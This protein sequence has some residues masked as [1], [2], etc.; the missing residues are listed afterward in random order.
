MHILSDKYPFFINACR[1][2]F[3]IRLPQKAFFENCLSVVARTRKEGSQADIHAFVK[4][5]FHLGDRILGGYIAHE[6]IPLR[7]PGLRGC[8]LF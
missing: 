7:K 3:V 6:L 1:V 5:E 4:L 8:L 2:Y